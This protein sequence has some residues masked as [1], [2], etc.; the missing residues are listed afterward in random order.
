MNDIREVEM[1]EMGQAGS[2]LVSHEYLEDLGPARSYFYR[3]SET[4]LVR[5]TSLFL[6]KS[7][8]VSMH[9]QKTKPMI[10]Q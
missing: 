3:Y 4:G 5:D 9:L 7:E 6:P 10:P 8:L 2:S 1:T